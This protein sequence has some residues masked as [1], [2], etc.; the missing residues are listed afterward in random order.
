MN[1]DPQP[2]PNDAELDELL[3]AYALDAIDDDERRLVEAYL[4][5][6]PLARAEVDSHRMVAAALGNLGREA[7]MPMRTGIPTSPVVSLAGRG[8]QRFVLASGWV[9]AAAAVVG[10]VVVSDRSSL[11]R[12]EEAAATAMAATA[13]E[14]NAQRLRAELARFRSGPGARA[15]LLLADPTI[16]RTVL[17]DADGRERATV[18]IDRTGEGYLI[19]S[20]LPRLPEGQ[21]Y[22]LWGVHGDRVLSVGVL[23]PEVRVV[24]FAAAPAPDG[25]PFDRFV[26][27]AEQGAGVVTSAGPAV[28]AGVIA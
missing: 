7:P 12:S 11:R 3:G 15:E 20:N 6:S 16:E 10:M 8:R 18:V 21:T 22:Q 27:T 2:L 1:R 23:G 4:L 13:A 9:A 14:T 5:R 25:E 24:G 26:L 19:A 28:A 17:N